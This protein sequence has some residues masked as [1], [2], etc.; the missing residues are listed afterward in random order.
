MLEEEHEVEEK[1][2]VDPPRR[3]IKEKEVELV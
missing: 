1:A 3:T 2:W